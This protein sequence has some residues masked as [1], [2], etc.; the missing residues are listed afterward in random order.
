MIQIQ[1]VR[2]R[3]TILLILIFF[4]IGLL[5]ACQPAAV[6]EINLPT[7][8]L[9]PTRTPT[10]APTATPPWIREGWEI[11]W[12][13]EF[14][15]E[16]LDPEKWT[17]EIGGH[18]WGNNEKQFYVDR[19]ENVRL[20]DGHLVIEANNEFFIRRHLHLVVSKLRTSSHLPMDV[21]KL[22]CSCLMDRGSGQLSGCLGVILVQYRG[23]L[24]VRLILW[25]ILVAN[26]HGCMVRFMVQVIPDR[27]A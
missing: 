23:H 20:E 25:N 27:V 17:M 16:Q 24:V 6:E 5:S 4:L 26:Q 3:T 12:Q 8:T 9:Q 21:W 15:G 22:V 2:S 18:G 11:I 1:P 7:E 10:T 14:D 19:P 13:D